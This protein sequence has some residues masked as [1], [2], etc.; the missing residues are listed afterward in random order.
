M[1]SLVQ[2]SALVLVSATVSQRG[3]MRLAAQRAKNKW[4]LSAQFQTG[5]LP[6][7]LHHPDPESQEISQEGAEGWGE[8]WWGTIFWTYF[9]HGNHH[10]ACIEA[11]IKALGMGTRGRWGALLG[12]RGSSGMRRE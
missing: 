1:T 6:Y 4:L 3:D 5:F 8:V 7:H 9:V 10:T 2:I 12:R 11:A